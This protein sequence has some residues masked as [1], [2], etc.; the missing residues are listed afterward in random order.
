MAPFLMLNKQLGENPTD[1]QHIQVFSIRQ[2]TDM[3][4]QAY[5]YLI[6]A[7]GILLGNNVKHSYHIIP[8]RHFQPELM[9]LDIYSLRGTYMHF[10]IGLNHDEQLKCLTFGTGGIHEYQI[11][12]RNLFND[13]DSLKT[14]LDALT[15]KRPVGNLYNA[16]M[17]SE[18]LTKLNAVAEK[19]GIFFEH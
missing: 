6:Y 13:N 15:N 19:S 5:A 12:D 18:F 16:L 7:S 10:T 9:V 8:N 17:V 2:H 14:Q 4:H 1:F 3:N 11:N